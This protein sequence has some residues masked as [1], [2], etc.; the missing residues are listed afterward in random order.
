VRPTAVN[1][2][3]WIRARF[4]HAGAYVYS[5]RI[6]SDTPVSYELR[7]APVIATGDSWP[8]GQAATQNSQA[9]DSTAIVRAALAATVDADSLWHRFAVPPATHRVLLVRDAACVACTLPCRAP[10]RCVLHPSQL[11]TVRR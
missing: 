3:S 9:T 4:A 2:A 10:Q 8:T 7:I 1:D 5:A 6:A 11:T